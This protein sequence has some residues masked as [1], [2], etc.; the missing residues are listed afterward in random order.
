MRGL[1]QNYRKRFLRKTGICFSPRNKSVV[2]STPEH[3]PTAKQRKKRYLIIM[4][5]R[6]MQ[7]YLCILAG[8]TTA[9]HIFQYTNINYPL[10]YE[11]PF[12]A[13]LNPVAVTVVI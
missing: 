4:N 13:T 8:N 7:N 1:H 11:S 3:Q 10:P 5:I 12:T 2:L 9:M 6:K